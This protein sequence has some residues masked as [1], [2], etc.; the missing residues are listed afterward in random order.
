MSGLASGYGVSGLVSGYSVWFSIG[1]LRLWFSVGVQCLVYCR[2]T[3]SL[4]QHRG[5]AS[6]VSC[7]GVASSRG[8]VVG[9]QPCLPSPSSGLGDRSLPPTSVSG[10]SLFPPRSLPPCRVHV[11]PRLFLCLPRVLGL[12]GHSLLWSSGSVSC[13]FWRFSFGSRPNLTLFSIKLGMINARFQGRTR[14]T[15]VGEMCFLIFVLNTGY[16]VWRTVSCPMERRKCRPSV[17]VGSASQGR[18]LLWIKS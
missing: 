5:M 4:V 15:A 7:R 14:N 2:G 12:W 11:P 10:S 8:A 18:K 17:P 3:A 1:A 9:P 16:P 13:L 6:L